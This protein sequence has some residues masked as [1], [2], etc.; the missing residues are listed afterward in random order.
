MTTHCR[1]KWRAKCNWVRNGGLLTSPPPT[2]M[3]MPESNTTSIVWTTSATTIVK[4]EKNLPKKSSESANGS[5]KSLK[6]Y[7]YIKMDIFSSENILGLDKI[8]VLFLFIV[9]HQ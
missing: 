7:N 3:I 8:S 9:Y 1:H 5:E 6:N 2:T 4:P